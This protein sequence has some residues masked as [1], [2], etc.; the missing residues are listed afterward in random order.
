VCFCPLLH[1]TSVSPTDLSDARTGERRACDVERRAREKCRLKMFCILEGAFAKLLET[2]LKDQD[3]ECRSFKRFRLDRLECVGKARY[4]ALRE[5]LIR[6]QGAG[7]K[8]EYYS[9]K[10]RANKEIKFSDFY[11]LSPPFTGSCTAIRIN[12]RLLS[13]L[14]QVHRT[15]ILRKAVAY[16]AL[17][18]NGSFFAAVIH[19]FSRLFDAW[20]LHFNAFCSSY[21]F[22]QLVPAVNRKV[23]ILIRRCRHDRFFAG[24][25]IFSPPR[26]TAGI[27]RIRSCSAPRPVRPAAFW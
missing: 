2:V 15:G 11:C 9:R 10:Q 21:S 24:G 13:A 6:E 25:F 20:P 17:S 16:P 23:L 18:S 8:L 1:I 19:A 26:S 27:V 5:K 3:T 12:S 22:S 4:P 14:R 7:K